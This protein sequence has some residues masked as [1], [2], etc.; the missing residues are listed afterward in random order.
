MADKQDIKAAV[1]ADEW[2]QH[3][4]DWTN[5]LTL[6]IAGNNFDEIKKVI[7]NMKPER[8]HAAGEA[9]QQVANKMKTTL[10][11]IYA[12]SK[13][14]SDHWGGEAADK[15]M[16][17]MQKL[18]TQAYEIHRVSTQ[19]A[20]ALKAHAKMQQSWQ[21]VVQ[22]D[23]DWDSFGDYWFGDTHVGTE[24]MNALNDQTVRSNDNF[25]PQI[26]KDMP[27]SSIGDYDPSKVPP[28]GGMPPGGGHLPG[29]GGGVGHLPGSGLLPGSGHLPGVGSDL[30]G[31]GHLPGAG[32][33]TSLA[34][35]DPSKGLGGGGLPGGGMGGDPL[36]GAGTLGSGAGGLGAGGLTGGGR[37]RGAGGGG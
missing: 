26:Q 29:G 9:Y 33:G 27:Q 15:Q 16:Q 30:P 36:G 18:Y 3:H 14:L 10:E 2:Q 32:N 19:T 17:Q 31:S 11:N 35:Y 4:S 7:N 21:P 25:P 6:G 13:V 1:H 34:G 20:G 24:M 5:G 12:Q 37:G 8:V 22:N 28:G 23:P